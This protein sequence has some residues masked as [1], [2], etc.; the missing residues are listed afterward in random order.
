[1]SETTERRP[2][3]ARRRRPLPALIFLLVLALAALTVWWNVLSD[4]TARDEAKAAACSS[5]SAAPSALDPATV[6]LRVLNASDVAGRAGEVATTLQSRGFV[7]EE[8]ANDGS[9]I[10]VTGVGELRFGPRGAST[11]DFMALYLP[12]S[13]DRPDTRATAVVD[14]V[15][16]PDFAGLATQEQ[17]Q[18]ALA[19]IVDAEGAC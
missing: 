6:T 15:L 17:V 13:T 10:E 9:G 14:V 5:A 18:A 8:I 1:M 7:V 4:E 2:A 12:G 19:P 11:A 3:G 16:G